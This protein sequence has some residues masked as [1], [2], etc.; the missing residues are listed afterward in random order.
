ML[1]TSRN[2][3]FDRRSIPDFT[4]APNEAS[5]ASLPFG[6]TSY[7]SSLSLGQQRY[8][9]L[10]ISPVTSA[11]PSGSHCIGTSQKM[12]EDLLQSVRQLGE[13]TIQA[14]PGYPPLRTRLQ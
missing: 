2:S 14:F 12:A 5:N 11:G 3:T 7:L 9:D 8:N 13:C 10:T 6:D 1:V 4:P